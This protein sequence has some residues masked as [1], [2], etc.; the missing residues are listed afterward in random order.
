[1]IATGRRGNIAGKGRLASGLDLRFTTGRYERARRRFGLYP[2]ISTLTSSRSGAAAS[3]NAAGVWTPFA[4]GVQRITDKGLFQDA[5][6]STN[7]TTFNNANPT[8]TTGVSGTVALVSDT[9]ALAAAGL[10]SLVSSGQVFKIDNSGGGSTIFTT[11]PGG[12]ANTS[13]HTVSAWVRMGAGTSRIT[14]D[15]GPFYSPAI[16]SGSYSRVS[17]TG[18][19]G[20]TGSRFVMETQ[21][22]SVTYLILQQLEQAATASSPI[23]TTSAAVTRSVDVNTVTVPPGCTTWLATYSGGTTATGAVT[24]GATFDFG[25]A[26]AGAWIGGH[27]ERLQI[28]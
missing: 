12:T 23:L 20:S 7:R 5:A 21:A 16:T 24:P 26:S 11:F 6:A 2:D 9:V 13:Q 17:A 22:N 10:A 15:A 1:M 27:L 3:L 19:P 18:T 28:Y 4:T 8:V 25:P 14:L